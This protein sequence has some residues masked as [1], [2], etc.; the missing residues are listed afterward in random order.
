MEHTQEDTNCA[1]G[2]DESFDRIRRVTKIDTGLFKQ[3][4]Q[5]SVM[6]NTHRHC[7]PSEMISP[8]YMVVFNIPPAVANHAAGARFPNLMAAITLY[9][10]RGR[11][12]GDHESPPTE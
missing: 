10:P 12:V 5:L 6:L 11:H 4:V 1:D 3:S 7:D 8:T 9:I 2:S